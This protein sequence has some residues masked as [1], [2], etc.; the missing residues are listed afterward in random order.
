MWIKYVIKFE[1]MIIGV[2]Y[3]SKRGDVVLG[4]SIR[5][6]E[7]IRKVLLEYFK[8]TAK[9][10]K[11]GWGKV[12]FRFIC[13]EDKFFTVIGKLREDDFTLKN[14]EVLEDMFRNT[15]K[16]EWEDQEDV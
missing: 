10:K 7:L 5:C 11:I 16:I 12:K 13:S 1:G 14:V 2:K 4:G 15:N 6:I 8:V 9:K 3:H